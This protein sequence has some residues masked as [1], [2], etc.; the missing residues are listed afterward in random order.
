MMLQLCT[1]AMVRCD[2]AVRVSMP[3]IHPQNWL[4]VV[5]SSWL[6]AQGTHSARCAPIGQW[7]GWLPLW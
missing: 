5:E 1:M 3:I 2:N 7:E 4:P 6:F